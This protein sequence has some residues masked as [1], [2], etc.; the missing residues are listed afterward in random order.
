[1]TYSTPLY[2]IPVPDGTSL[3][4]N[5]PAELKAMGEGF[6]AALNAHVAI[7]VSNPAVVTATSEAA[8]DSYWGTPTTETARLTL[9]ARGATTIRT[10]KNITERFFATY[11]AA[12]NPQ[13]RTP[14]GWYAEEGNI[15]IAENATAR[16]QR[17]PSP[18][19]GMLTFL[20]D[21]NVIQ[22][23]I[24]GNWKQVYPAVD[25][26]T[27][28]QIVQVVQ[29]VKT[30]TWG[31]T[32]GT[33]TEVT[34]LAAT[35]TPKSS[36]N[37]ILVLT[38]I[39]YATS[40]NSSYPDIG[41]FKVTRG[42]TDIYLGNSS[43]AQIRA[44]FGGTANGSEYAISSGSVNYLDSPGTTSPVTYRVEAR[45]GRANNTLYVNRAWNDLS[46]EFVSRGAS[47]IILL[48]VVA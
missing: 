4:K 8:R 9:Q 25:V 35:I 42:G 32:S 38:Q 27:A 39:A 10:D 44:V 41:H 24:D 22:T 21:T 1:M 47:S 31:T 45:R 37:K 48:E 23:Y 28:G 15:L 36:T 18:T 11:N 33:F 19:E 7:P 17:F 6:E 20:S 29:V 34:G 3:A 16:S 46:A 5:L 26:P 43:G 13:G 30:D 12:S 14:A 2:G 40:G